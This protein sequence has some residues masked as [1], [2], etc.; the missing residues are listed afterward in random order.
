[1]DDFLE[2]KLA[3]RFRA[4]DRDGNGYLQ[5]QD[6]ELSAV[7][8]AEEF[9]HGPESPARKRLVEISLGLW[10]HLRKVADFDADERISLDEY[11]AAFAAGMLETPETFD[12]SYV[13]YINAVMDIAD[14]DHD[15]RLTVSDEI[16]WMGTLMN[17]P[18]QVTR[19][20]FQ[21]IDKDGDGFITTR[22]L[23]ETIR[24]YYFDD[25]PD[26]PG[27]W[28]LGSLYP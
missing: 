23:L 5:R 17:M 13:P 6:F 3:R 15:G 22:D 21:R 18:E 28:L 27:H 4:H 19:A 14:Q 10:D 20:A 7:H 8:M 24:A 16:R 26:A 25:S 11:K 1:M 12:Q 9:G 2:R